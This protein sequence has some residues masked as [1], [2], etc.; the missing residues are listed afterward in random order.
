MAGDTLDICA[1]RRDAPHE[2]YSLVPR[3]NMYDVVHTTSLLLISFNLLRIIKAQ[4]RQLP[5]SFND[6]RD[7][8]EGEQH[9]HLLG[10]T[11]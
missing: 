2:V 8:D 1:L 3:L 5:D 11:R 9:D 6:R 4:S 10:R 7:E